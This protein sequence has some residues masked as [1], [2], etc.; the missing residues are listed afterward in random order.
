MTKIPF[1]PFVLFSGKVIF[2]HSKETIKTEIIIKK[3][4]IFFFKT[5]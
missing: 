5:V 4:Q 2:D 1:A 3:K